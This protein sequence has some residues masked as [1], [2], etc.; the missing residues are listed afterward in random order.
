MPPYHTEVQYWTTF[1]PIFLAKVDLRDVYMWVWVRAENTPLLASVVP[2]HHYEPEHLMESHTSLTM[3]YVKYTQLFFC[4][5]ETVINIINFS[6]PA[7]PS[8]CPHLLKAVAN[9]LSAPDNDILTGCPNRNISD[10]LRSLPRKPAFLFLL[11]YVDLYMEYFCALVQGSTKICSQ[12]HRHLF[13][14]TDLVFRPNK[15][16]DGVHHE[17]NR[18]N[19]LHCWDSAWTT[20]K[21][22]IGWIINSIH[23]IISLPTSRPKRVNTDLFQTKT[24]TFST[25]ALIWVHFKTVH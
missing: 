9:I 2:P 20:H 1:G 19:N 18:T 21:N 4:A 24:S 10:L 7:A 23:H 6:W 25:R 12:Y 22:I 8:A 5:M 11:Q 14:C 3:G 13:H 16:S 17:P 15:N